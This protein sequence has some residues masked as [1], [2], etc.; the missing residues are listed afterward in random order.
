MVWSGC[1]GNKKSPSAIA[2]VGSNPT[3]ISRLG[4]G[5]Q[6]VNEDQQVYR[7]ARVL[8]HS[9]SRDHV[10][11]G[12]DCGLK[13]YDR[14]L[15]K[16][17]MPVRKDYHVVPGSERTA[18]VNSRIIGQVDPKEVLTITVRVRRPTVSNQLQTQ[19]IELSRR[20]PGKRNYLSRTQFTQ[21]NT[22]RMRRIS[23]RSRRLLTNTDSPSRT[24][25]ARNVR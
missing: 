6:I 4:L 13:V 9:D 16:A 1:G 18:P 22:A 17:F 3:G 7:F 25:A 24:P 23:P 5:E 14:H 2:L 8:S 20:A 21:R 19:S 11:S 12:P 10:D 15:H